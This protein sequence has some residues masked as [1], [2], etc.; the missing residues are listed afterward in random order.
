MLG[1][2]SGHTYYYLSEVKPRLV[3]PEKTSLGDLWNL[4]AHGKL[5]A[6]GEEEAEAGAASDAAEDAEDAE[7]AEGDGAADGDED[8]E[9]GAADPADAEECAEDEAAAAGGKKL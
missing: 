7:A 6:I 9:E 2:M 5:L 3:L 8:A 4:L 1:I